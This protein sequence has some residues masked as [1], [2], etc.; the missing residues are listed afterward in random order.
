MEEKR[1]FWV[2]PVAAIAST[3]PVIAVLK[4]TI[5]GID[6]WLL[7]RTRGRMAVTG[8]LP[9]LLLTTTGRKSG[10][11]RSAPLLYLNHGD[12]WVVIGTNFGGASHPA[13]Y[14]NLKADPRAELLVEGEKVKVS[15]REATEDER[16]ELWSKAMHIY[17]GYKTYKARVVSR[18]VPMVVLSRA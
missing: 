8:G 7:R 11:P 5:P 16:S 4:R 9:T 13:W 18:Q 17:P 3:R 12:D 1:P 14:L 2:R 10:E 15:A 6:R